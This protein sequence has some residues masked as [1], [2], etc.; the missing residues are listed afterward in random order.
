MFAAIRP[1]GQD[2]PLL[3]HLVGAT[4]VFG[5]LLASIASL[6][7]AR[8]QARLL[9]LGYYSLLFVALPGMALM[10]GAGE[11]LY[12]KQGWNKLPSDLKN[13]DW[14]TIGFIV[15]DYGGLFF[16]A[17]LIVGGVGIR[18]LKNGTSDGGLLKV[19][20]VMAL[21]LAIG[22]IVAVW[23]MTGKPTGSSSAPAVAASNTAT[24]T[25]V[26]VDATEFR[27]TLSKTQVPHGTVVF[28]LVNQGKI[29]HDFSINGETSALVA[30]GK[31]TTLTISLAAGKYL[32]VCTVPGHANAGM[33]GTL[34]AK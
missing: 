20:M 32:Y 18:R 17:A 5:G 21:V 24:S 25:A 22:Y 2:F 8:G 10:W 13:V 33:Q 30:A 28:T 15:G 16:I 1:A 27:F 6:A 3:L 29:S 9:R 7:L 19:T 26:T 4:V 23:A 11:W 31:S 12:H 34:T 14:L